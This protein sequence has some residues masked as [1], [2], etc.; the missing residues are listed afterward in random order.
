MVAIVKIHL[1]GQVGM[2]TALLSSGIAHHGCLL[3]HVCAGIKV[4]S[5]AAGMASATETASNVAQV[6]PHAHSRS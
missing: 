6:G 5:F 2:R 4:S 3:S 1:L